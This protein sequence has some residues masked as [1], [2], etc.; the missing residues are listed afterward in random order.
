[1]S[2]HDTYNSSSICM[3]QVIE[4]QYLDQRR[5]M[6]LLKQVYGTSG[7]KNNFR[8]ELRLNRYKIYPMDQT[9]KLTEVDL[10]DSCNKSMPLIKP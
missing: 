5:F 7:G 8:V 6:N 10:L 4:G 3:P 2:S 9:T 1:M